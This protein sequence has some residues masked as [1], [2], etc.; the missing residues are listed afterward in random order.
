[1]LMISTARH[2]RPLVRE[3][4]RGN[5]TQTDEGRVRFQN[6]FSDRIEAGQILGRRLKYLIADPDVI[7]LALPRGGVPVGSRLRKR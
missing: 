3:R 7:V 5:G 4:A 1:V 2:G 6:P